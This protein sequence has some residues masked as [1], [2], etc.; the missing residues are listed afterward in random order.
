MPSPESAMTKKKITSLIIFRRKVFEHS[1]FIERTQDGLE[2]QAIKYILLKAAC[3][4]YL[5]TV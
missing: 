3:L 5:L 2:I 4:R 1:E